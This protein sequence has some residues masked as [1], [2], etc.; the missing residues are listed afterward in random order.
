MILLIPPIYPFLSR[1]M[2]RMNPTV[3]MSIVNSNPTPINFKN[4]P[5]VVVKHAD[6]IIPPPVLGQ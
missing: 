5:A 2:R 3:P 6:Q 4:L 1:K